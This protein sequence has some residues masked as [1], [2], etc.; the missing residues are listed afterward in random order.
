MAGKV[1]VPTEKFT[2]ILLQSQGM[3]VKLD[4]KYL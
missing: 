1:I 3:P 2:A 4:F